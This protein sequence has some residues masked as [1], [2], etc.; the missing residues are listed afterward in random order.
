MIPMSNRYFIDREDAACRLAA[1]LVRFK[2]RHPLVLAIPRGGVPIGRIVADALDG[3][4][5]VV[6]VRKL[7]APGNP[8]LA[9]GAID[10]DGNVHLGAHAEQAG[11]DAAYV[12]DE[13][14]RQLAL[15]RDRRASY[16]AGRTSPDP[17]GRDV[18]MVDDGLATGATMGAALQAVRARHP[19][20]LVCA[21][22]VAAPD[23]LR[24]VAPFADEVVCLAAPADFNAVGQFYERFAPVGD[25]EVV[26]LLAEAGTAAASDSP[27][28]RMVAV[29]GDGVVLEGELCV[30]ANARGLVLFAHGSGSSRHSPR[31]R[32]VAGELNRVRL[33]TLLIDLLTPVEDRERSSRF[34]IVLL[35]RR[36]GVVI[37]WLGRDPVVSRLPVGLFGAS[38][39]A[40]A[41]LI[42][43]VARAQRIAAV[44]ARGGRPDLV[45]RATLARLQAPVLLIVGGADH[46]VLEL[47]RGAWANMPESAEL[48]VVPGATHLFEEP[49]A[50]ELVAQLAADWFVSWL[51]P[52]RGAAGVTP[53][54]LTS[55]AHVSARADRAMLKRPPR[56]KRGY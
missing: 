29:P 16:G 38:T 54:S 51:P 7:G 49:N 50:L 40:A 6:L 45:D 21:V 10:E 55:P 30:P 18:I 9:I 27:V 43:A 12:R 52:G 11:A 44:V 25:E 47:N 34:D 31:N 14:A 37:D 23:S 42:A 22:P 28:S 46:E 1:A 53:P 13:A 2:G 3:E 41:A 36:L 20:R 26:S 32:F 17:A 33:A 15:I 39:G 56:A 48:I 24:R 35:A 8:E 19:A 5:D 4:L